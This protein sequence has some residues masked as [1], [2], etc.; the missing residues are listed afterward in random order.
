MSTV[1]WHI[2][3]VISMLHARVRWDVPLTETQWHDR[4]K[5]TGGGRGGD[6]IQSLQSILWWGRDRWRIYRVLRGGRGGRKT[7]GSANEHGWDV[8]AQHRVALA[9]EASDTGGSTLSLTRL[10]LRPS[11]GIP[12]EPPR[13][14]NPNA[15]TPMWMLDI[16]AFTHAGPKIRIQI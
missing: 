16:P 9:A 6:F 14:A 11:G 5:S 4:H 15:H 13:D 12:G 10:D 3:A 1:N 2:Q 7:R 8:F